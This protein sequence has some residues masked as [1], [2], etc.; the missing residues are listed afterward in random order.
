MDAAA[1]LRP[2]SIEPETLYVD[3]ALLR[4][5][6]SEL[7]TAIDEPGDCPDELHTE[8]VSLAIPSPTLAVVEAGCFISLRLS[9]LQHSLPSQVMEVLSD[10]VGVIWKQ[11]DEPDETL[12]KTHWV[13]VMIDRRCS[14]EEKVRHNANYSEETLDND[15]S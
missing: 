13:D 8:Q 5:G 6:Q 11:Y 3:P 4:Q 7:Q 10:L 12:L 15:W 14:F 1:G 2:Y 9:V